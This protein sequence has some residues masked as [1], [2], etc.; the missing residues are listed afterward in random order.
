MKAF[1]MYRDRDFDPD[2]LLSR[3][4]RVRFRLGE[5]QKLNLQW[6]LPWN[7]EELR[8]DL[9]L[10]VLFDAMADNDD[11]L[12]EVA[13]VGVLSGATD[14]GAILYRQNILSDCI[15]NEAVI[16]STY[17]LLTE[18]IEG[19]KSYFWV[20][21]RS[22]PTTTLHRAV[23]LLEMYTETLKKLRHIS[24]THANRFDSEGFT[25]LF[26]M[27]KEELSD[28]FFDKIRSHFTL[29]K[30]RDGA[31]ISA[32]LGKGNKGKNYVLRVP[33]VDKRSWFS[34]LLSEAPSGYTFQLHPRDENGFNTLSTLKDQGVNIVANTLAQSADHILGFFQMLRTELAFYIGCLNLRERL[35]RLGEPTCRPVPF[36]AGDRKLSF[37]GLYDPSLALSKGQKLV[38]NDIEADHK[39]LLVVTGANTGGKSTFLRS[40]GLAQLMMQAGM[41]APAQ[42]FSSEISA[43]VVTHF[44]REEDVA[45]VSGKWDEELAR[46]NAIVDHLKPN[47]ILLFNESFSSTNEREGSEIAKQIVSALVEMKVK[48][49]FVTHLYH[50][51]QGAYSQH[52]HNVAFLRAERKPDGTRP[53][54]LAEGEPLQTSYGEDLY[55]QIFGDNLRKDAAQQSLGPQI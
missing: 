29:L 8:K 15:K 24:D 13:K 47:S 45:M 7:E 44:K 27:L 4:D 12:F 36:A 46:M 32:E 11:F 41:F 52:M 5:D 53:F 28:E 23:R 16:R 31:L 42:A 33:H 43:G 40:V 20:T 26:A 1:L 48:A 6:L 30:F 49:L 51:A 38:G 2:Q 34:R 21:R 37:F 19:E 39:D 50:F 14:I 22:F 55:E 3:R 54:K 10:D 18:A 35:A 17:K 25:A 9:G